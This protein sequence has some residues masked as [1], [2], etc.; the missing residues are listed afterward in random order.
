MHPGPTKRLQRAPIPNCSA[1]AQGGQGIRIFV[2][3]SPQSLTSRDARKHPLTSV[4]Y[5]AVSARNHASAQPKARAILSIPPAL[6]ARSAAASKERRNAHTLR[7]CLL[8]RCARISDGVRS[9]TAHFL[10][11]S[12]AAASLRT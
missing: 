4:A 11:A 8:R 1:P 10:C 9:E 6:A 12:N 3:F 2:K 7:R 5:H